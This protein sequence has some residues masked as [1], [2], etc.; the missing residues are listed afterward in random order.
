MVQDNFLFAL[1]IVLP[2]PLILRVTTPLYNILWDAD[3]TN[4]KDENGTTDV[5][6]SL[7]VG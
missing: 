3:P 1:K 4:I 6:A 7:A 2:L 5:F